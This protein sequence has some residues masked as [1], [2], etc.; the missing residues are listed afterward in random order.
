MTG[1]MN[2]IWKASGILLLAYVIVRGFSTPLQ[3]GFVE[4]TN[5][6]YEHVYAEPQ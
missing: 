4:A 5:Y 6:V 3:P 1:A 2:A